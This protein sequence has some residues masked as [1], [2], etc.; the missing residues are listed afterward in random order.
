MAVHH[1]CGFREGLITENNP[2]FHSTNLSLELCLSATQGMTPSAQRKGL[3][4]AAFGPHVMFSP[5]CRTE[6]VPA[7]ICSAI[8]TL[9]FLVEAKD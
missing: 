2:I 1:F 4:P 3:L 9:M 7:R 8:E 6:G 5:F